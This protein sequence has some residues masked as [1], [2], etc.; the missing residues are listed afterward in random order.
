M[1]AA[2]I[3]ENY[4]SETPL[5][6]KPWAGLHQDAAKALIVHE[7]SRILAAA[8]EGKARA[9]VLTGSLS[10][11][12][13]TLQQDGSLWRVLGDA[14][15][16]IVFDQ[17]IRVET[18]NLEQEIQCSLLRQGVSCKVVVVTSIA[19]NLRAMKPHI[20]AYELKERGVVLWGDKNALS[21]IPAF[22]ASDIPK[23]DGWWLLCN[24]MIEQIETAAATSTFDDNCT[25]VRYRIAKLYLAMAACYLLVTG[26]YEPSYQSRAERLKQIAETNPNAPPPLPLDRF[27]HLVSHC[28][29]LKMHGEA[30]VPLNDFPCWA[31]AV[32]DAEA[33]WRWAAAEILGTTA[34][35]GSEQLLAGLA[36]RQSKP[37]RAK[38]WLRA[39]VSYRS[40]LTR[41]WHRWARLALSSSPRYLVYGAA[42]ELFSMT[43]RPTSAN[44]VQL[45]K[46][47][48]N[49]P[50]SLDVRE[51]DLTWVAVAKHVALNFHALLENNRC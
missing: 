4:E 45:A 15:F 24:R 51:Q 42:R 38:G 22:G 14:T 32:A 11:D 26:R 21:L 46:I 27:S 28:T 43:Q 40:G 19:D 9:I 35:L 16:L 49:L 7:G 5:F 20:Y 47:V 33:M 12:E 13:A 34:N 6:A 50:I 39:A 18:N 23:E 1:T 37:G 17:P 3:S 36:A 44:N 31:D 10:R 30:G 29:D 48:K 25:A 2:V 41:E 8:L